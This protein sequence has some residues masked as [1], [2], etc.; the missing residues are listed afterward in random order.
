[1]TPLVPNFL[2]LSLIPAQDQA[3]RCLTRLLCVFALSSSVAFAQSLEETRK[4]AESGDARAQSAPGTMYYAGDGAPK[5]DA[6][7]VKSWRK[8]A[9]QGHAKG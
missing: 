9:D 3:M 8:A 5:D 2:G 4:R 7:A 1:M 6:E